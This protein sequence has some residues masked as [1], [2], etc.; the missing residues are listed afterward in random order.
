MAIAAMTI[1]SCGSNNTKADLKND[2]DTLSYAVGV[3][4]GNQFT[5]MQVL[6]YQFGIDSAYVADFIRGVQE[7]ANAGEDKKKAAYFA[8]L[9]IGQ[10]IAQQIVPNVNNQFFGEDS[11]KRVS[12]NNLIAAF[13]S[14]VKGETAK[15]TATEADSL[16]EAFRTK[17]LNATIAAGQAFL[18]ENATKEGVQTTESGLQYKV[19]VKGEGPVPTKE[20]R[21]KVNYEGTLLD[22]TVFDSSIQRGEPATFRVDQVIAGWTEALQMMPVGSKWE[23]F[24][25]QNLAY[26]ERG[27][28]GINPGE[29][30]H[31]TVE[32]LEIVKEDKK[33]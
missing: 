21:V 14:L 12:V 23:L 31:F 15:F 2:I 13:V 7:S 8:G 26:G 32:L 3:S 17:K 16:Q 10:Q 9:Q 18:A 27:T 29:A 24:I 5:Q 30:L 19:I 6:S 28:R 25:P 4:I 33:K 11:T 1:T 22:G 20:D